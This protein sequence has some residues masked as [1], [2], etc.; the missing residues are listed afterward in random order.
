[1]QFPGKD[2]HQAVH[3]QTPLP[4]SLV[5]PNLFHTPV[6]PSTHKVESFHKLMQRQTWKHTAGMMALTARLC[7]ASLEGDFNEDVVTTDK[8]LL[9]KNKMC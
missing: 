2:T 9:W 6:S 3:Q 4:T 1:M 8:D 5:A 7:L